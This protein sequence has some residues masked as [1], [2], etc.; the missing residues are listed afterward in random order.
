MKSAATVSKN[1]DQPSRRETV[2]K[3]GVYPMSGPL[4]SSDAPIRGQMEWGQGRRGVAGYEDHGSSELSLESGALIGGG[5]QPWSAAEQETC[6]AGAHCHE[7]A[8]AEWP[9]F[10]SWF[11]AS[12]RGIEVTIE[13]PEGMQARNRPLNFLSAHLLENEVDAITVAVKTGSRLRRLN[14]TGAKH[15]RMYCNA[16]G[17]PTEIRIETTSG[18]E[19]VLRFNESGDS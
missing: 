10:C 1:V 4:P 9:A 17:W 18:G 15:L 19:T 2:G 3:S 12:F 7:V 16:A 14:I 13:T 5:T 11:S 8:V 6:P